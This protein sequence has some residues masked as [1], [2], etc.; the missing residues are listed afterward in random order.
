MVFTPA[1]KKNV[2]DKLTS[3]WSGPFIISKKLSEILY[4]AKLEQIK[5][6]KVLQNLPKE[7]SA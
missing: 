7:S 5:T 2:S 1:R 4:K 3:G 6:M